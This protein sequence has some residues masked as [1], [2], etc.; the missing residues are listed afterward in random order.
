MYNSGKPR[1]YL[2]SNQLPEALNL[3]AKLSD[4]KVPEAMYEYSNLALQNKNENESLACSQAFD[5]LT[6]AANKGYTPAKRTLGFLYCFADNEEILRASNYYERCTYSKNVSKG[7]QLL[8]QA[9]L[10]GDTTASRLL[11][12]LNI[13]Q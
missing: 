6:E 1:Q 10:Q 13:K 2:N 4:Q 8:I 11:D 5:M 7:S 3:Y 12:D 9:M